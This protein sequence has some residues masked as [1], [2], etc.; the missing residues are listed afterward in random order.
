MEENYKDFE[1]TCNSLVE[2]VKSYNFRSIS[3]LRS[4]TI[5]VLK[6]LRCKGQQ[7]IDKASK[8][9]VKKFYF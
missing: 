7:E 6:Y 1:S 5:N 8:R 3:E 2:H 9:V 4:F